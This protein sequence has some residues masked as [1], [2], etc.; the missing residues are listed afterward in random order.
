MVGICGESCDQPGQDEGEDDSQ[1]DIPAADA[2]VLG[3]LEL[4]HFDAVE[5][6]PINSRRE[7]QVLFAQN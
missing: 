6:E 5:K 3:Y 4:G 1:G 7:I 2:V